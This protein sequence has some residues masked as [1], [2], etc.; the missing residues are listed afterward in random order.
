M[1]YI[2][3]YSSPKSAERCHYIAKTDYFD[4]HG[5]LQ[6][7]YTTHFKINH[8]STLALMEWSKQNTSAQT[9]L[10]AHNLH[11]ITINTQYRYEVQTLVAMM[12]FDC[13]RR[14]WQEKWF[15]FMLKNK[16][17]T[18]EELCKKA[19]RMKQEQDRL[20]NIRGKN[21]PFSE[22][23]AIT[24]Q[25]WW[26]KRS[27][28]FRIYKTLFQLIDGLLENFDSEKYIRNVYSFKNNK[29]KILKIQEG[30]M[31]RVARRRIISKNESNKFVTV[32]WRQ[33][34]DIINKE[35]ERRLCNIM[36]HVSDTGRYEGDTLEFHTI[37]RQ[38]PKKKSFWRK[39][40][41]ML[42]LDKR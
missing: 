15:K 42:G 18:F 34:D 23:C 7:A 10:R 37:L 29:K 12:N 27:R 30:I 19:Y 11:R 36:R 13:N 21:I 41:R 38:D 26:R 40:A 3:K 2:E 35:K 25:R 5:N 28:K 14:N 8:I 31:A 33:I 1:E 17:I 6:P 9:I 32:F 22:D 16:G 39:W 24:I 20:F 4:K